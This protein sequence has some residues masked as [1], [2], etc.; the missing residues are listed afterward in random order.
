MASEFAKVV[1]VIIPV[2]NDSG[3]LLNCLRALEAQTYPKS[4][5]EVIV[6]DNGSDEAL[7]PQVNGFAH[8][9]VYREPQPGSY[10]ARN[11]GISHAKG[12]IIA[13]TDADCIPAADWL[14]N[15]VAALLAIR[16]RGLVGGCV[17]VFYRDPQCPSAVELYDASRGFRQEKY[18]EV[19]RYGAT[20][21]M[22]TFRSMFEKV[23][24][25]DDELKSYGDVEWGRRV[26]NHGYQL[27][28]ASTAVVAHPARDTLSA[29]CRRILRVAGGLHDLQRRDLHT[30]RDQVTLS[31][32]PDTVKSVWRDPRLQTFGRRAQVI[33]VIGLVQ[34]LKLFERGRLRLGGMS[35]R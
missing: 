5:Y 12:E 34:C 32:I 8:V 4:D 17:D 1:S 7:E 31:S 6:V 30:P 18:I 25:F 13:F 33:A 9:R 3:R 21:N 2:F 22:F 26:A 35:R 14:E 11:K 23:G 16:G 24:M 20:A 15:G 29:L 27:A 28:Y 10:A 19:D